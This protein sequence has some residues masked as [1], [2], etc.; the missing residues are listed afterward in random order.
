MF[1]IRY[2]THISMQGCI[3][4][5]RSHLSQFMK[6]QP[7]KDTCITLGRDMLHTFDPKFAPSACQSH[8]AKNGPFPAS[9]PQ[10]L[11]CSW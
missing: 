7:T 3:H 2:S 8:Q 6:F 1:D 9:A 11:S 5:C 10:V 4:P